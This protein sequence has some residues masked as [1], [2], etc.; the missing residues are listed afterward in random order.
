MCRLI[1]S[2]FGMGGEVN[3]SQPITFIVGSYTYDDFAQT[4]T[5][6]PYQALDS[7]LTGMLSE[8][9]TELTPITAASS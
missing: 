8:I 7:S 5:I 1:L 4:A 3:L 9:N 2:D 6:V